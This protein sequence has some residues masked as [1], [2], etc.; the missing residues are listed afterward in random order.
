VNGY[1]VTDAKT[2]TALTISENGWLS[3]PSRKIRVS[4]RGT[5]TAGSEYLTAVAYRVD[6]DAMSSDG[7]GDG[8][9]DCSAETGEAYPGQICELA[10]D[11]SS[12]SYI[13]WGSIVRIKGQVDADA[14]PC[15]KVPKACAALGVHDKTK[16]GD[17]N[18]AGA[19][20]VDAT[21]N[22]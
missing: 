6:D 10:T 19:W 3:S 22:P 11:F 1:R 7:N 16:P 15:P 17:S 18:D 21:R 20:K 8:L 13:A 12:G 5:V 4:L 14:S 2:R 9:A